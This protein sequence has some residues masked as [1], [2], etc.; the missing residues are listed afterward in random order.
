MSMSK[1]I[2]TVL[3]A[4]ILFST[5]AVSA[6][7]YTDDFNSYPDANE[8]QA[9][10][11]DWELAHGGKNWHIVDNNSLKIKGADPS[12][13]DNVVGDCYIGALHAGEG[14]QRVSIDYM[15]RND[16]NDAYIPQASIHLNFNGMSHYYFAAD[17]YRLSIRG[18][19]D[20]QVAKLAADGSEE[21]T[22]GWA[23]YAG[24][25]LTVDT[26]YR[27]TLEMDLTT[28]VLT[29]TVET[30]GGGLLGQLSITD[31]GTAHTGGYTAITDLY[32]IAGNV[33][34]YDNFEYEIVP[35]PATMAL[36]GLGGLAL[37]RRKK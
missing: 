13:A 20:M 31:T 6:V 27:L 16:G 19:K 4:V 2:L 15:P 35:E 7:T 11:P 1:N 9:V 22:S 36:L 18:V 29:G 26:W 24:G 12:G 14:Y 17:S 23:G 8:L 3:M 21:F 34:Y 25:D 32:G 37:I 28:K 10:S 33:C 30:L 5:G